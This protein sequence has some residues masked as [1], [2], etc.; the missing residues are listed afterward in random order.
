MDNHGQSSTLNHD[1][2]RSDGLNLLSQSLFVT[3]QPY[4]NGVSEQINH[5]SVR[6]LRTRSP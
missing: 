3:R 4:G 5:M 1:C 2:G 6:S